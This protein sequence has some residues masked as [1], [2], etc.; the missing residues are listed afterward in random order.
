LEEGKK[1]KKDARKEGEGEK[2]GERQESLK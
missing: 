2:C 1:A